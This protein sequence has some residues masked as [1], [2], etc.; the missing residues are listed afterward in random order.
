MAACSP[1]KARVLMMRFAASWFQHLAQECD[2]PT[3]K[4]IVLD[5]AANVHKNF[6]AH[7]SEH[8]RQVTRWTLLLFQSDSHQNKKEA[9]VRLMQCLFILGPEPKADA[10]SVV[11]QFFKNFLTH[12]TDP[13]SAPAPAPVTVP[14]PVPVPAPVGRPVVGDEQGRVHP[15]VLRVFENTTYHVQV[16]LASGARRCVVY[17][18]GAL[19][20]KCAHIHQQLAVHK[21][22][23]TQWTEQ[24]HRPQS[25][26]LQRAYA[27][28]CML[29]LLGMAPTASRAQE[30]L[31]CCRCFL[32][33]ISNFVKD[34]HARRTLGAEQDV[35]ALFKEFS[36]RYWL[37]V[38]EDARYHGWKSHALTKSSTDPPL[39]P[40]EKV[41]E[42]FDP[43]RSQLTRVVAWVVTMEDMGILHRVQYDAWDVL[44]AYDIWTHMYLFPHGAWSPARRHACSNPDLMEVFEQEEDTQNYFNVMRKI[45]L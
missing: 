1:E 3:R 26:P 10:I 7:G 16:G 19:S 34:G 31:K 42:L 17:I 18:W 25:T 43:N 40:M 27:F 14:V 24:V 30:Y 32:P 37:Q 23:V 2:D 22:Q 12:A 29:M 41:H 33:V 21:V 45:T 6:T 28:S 39:L 8:A 11:L 13:V 20:D 38:A 44:R 4:R 9:F 36:R 15:L 35:Y 5:R